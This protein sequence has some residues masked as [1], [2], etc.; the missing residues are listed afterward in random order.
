MEA[1]QLMPWHHPLN[2]PIPEGLVEHGISEE[3][4]TFHLIQLGY[5]PRLNADPAHADS[6]DFLPVPQS[7]TAWAVQ[8]RNRPLL[9]AAIVDDICTGAKIGAWVGLEP[10]V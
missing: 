9:V 5:Y 3:E 6:D 2:L 1:N 4:L 7:F 8:N 10:N